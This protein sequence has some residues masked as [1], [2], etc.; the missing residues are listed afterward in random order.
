MYLN[1][2]SNFYPVIVQRKS[3]PEIKTTQNK[4]Y[5]FTFVWI[6]IPCPH[7]NTS[8]TCIQ[9]IENLFVFL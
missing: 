2:G 4:S 6:S 8:N 3:L 1:T 9:L 7:Y 5:C